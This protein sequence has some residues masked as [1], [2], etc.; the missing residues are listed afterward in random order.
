MASFSTIHER[1]KIVIFRRVY[2]S[3]K[4]NLI[5]VKHRLQSFQLL[6]FDNR[7]IWFNISLLAIIHKI[8]SDEREFALFG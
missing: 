2:H 1:F 4:N 5:I 8:G 7:S 6:K 3:H